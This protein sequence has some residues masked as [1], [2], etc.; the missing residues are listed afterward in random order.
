MGIILNITSHDKHPPE[1][2][3]FMRTIKER[4]RAVFNTLPFEQYPNRLI[5]ETVYNAKFG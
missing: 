4:V 2:E 1:I 3:R 5:V